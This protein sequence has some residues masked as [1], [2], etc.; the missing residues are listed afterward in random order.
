MHGTYTLLQMSNTFLNISEYLKN[1]AFRRDCY[2]EDSAAK[3]EK[4]LFFHHK[5]ELT[6]KNMEITNCNKI[7]FVC[8]KKRKIFDLQQ[9]LIF[10]CT[11]EQ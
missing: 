6:R 2:D 7:Q 3:W 5:K 9:N 8:C 10:Y 1:T 11:V 4:K